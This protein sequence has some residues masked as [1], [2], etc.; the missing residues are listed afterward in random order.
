MKCPSEQ[1]HDR[2]ISVKTLLLVA[3]Y[4]SGVGYA[5]WLMESFWAKLAEHCH[6]QNPVILAYPSI[7]NV[8]P[9]ILKAP[10]SVMVQDFTGTSTSQI[11]AQCQFLLRNH[12]RIIYFSDKESWHW[13][14]ILYRVC[15]VRYII[16]HDHTPGLRTL[17]LGLK[18]C[19][20]RLVHRMPW[21]SVDGAIG[22]TE[23]IRQ[24]LIEVNGVPMERCYVAPN[25][26]PPQ[27]HTQGA[28]DLHRI[29]GIP[30]G[31]K[32][33]VMTG[34]ANRYKGVSFVLRC[35]AML[36]DEARDSLQFLFIGNGP[37]MANLA[38]TAIDT[39][40][41]GNCT[42]AG[43][44]EDVLT[45]LEGADIAIH[46][47]HGEVGYSL[48]ILEYMR[49]GLPV[50]VPDNPSVC[51]ATKHEFSG[52]IYPEGNVANA[53]SVLLRLLYDDALRSRLGAR[54]K[55]AVKQYSLKA[56]HVGLLNAFDEITSEGV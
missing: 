40:I 51:G 50:V 6:R 49:A 8:S 38:A 12:V 43:R 18:A 53:T 14:Y 33:L 11:L 44:R 45:L 2:G 10:L 56:T 39:G 24:R 19:L 23:F 42:F 46:P 27:N 31:R 54:A 7:S 26:L 13:R 52:L 28:A 1:V 22:A 32:I 3:N 55:L 17:S 47:S 30:N 20:K 37:D 21:L 36:P 5:W 15:G 48:S 29:F 16:V 35:I 34:R 41:A 4:D 9:T 25:G